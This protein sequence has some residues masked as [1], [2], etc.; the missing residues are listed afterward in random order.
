MGPASRRTPTR[1]IADLVL[2]PPPPLRAPR[3][4]SRTALLAMAASLA[5]LALAALLLGVTR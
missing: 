5:L 2:G 4:R 1:T 3:A